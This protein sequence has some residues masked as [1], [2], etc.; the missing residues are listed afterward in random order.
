MGTPATPRSVKGKVLQGPP[1]RT[2]QIVGQLVLRPRN[3]SENAHKLVLVKKARVL[4]VDNAPQLYGATRMS[5]PIP[6]RILD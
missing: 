1:L 5:A 6:M 3:Q 2:V 4:A